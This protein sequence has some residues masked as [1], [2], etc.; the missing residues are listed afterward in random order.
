MN[1]VIYLDDF[2]NHIFPKHVDIFEDKSTTQKKVLQVIF[3][4]K[5]LFKGKI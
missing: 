3:S 2:K 5:V 1:R 4:G